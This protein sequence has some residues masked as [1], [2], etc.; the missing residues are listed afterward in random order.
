MSYF[1]IHVSL[2]KILLKMSKKSFIAGVLFSLSTCLSAQEIRETFHFLS[3]P[4]ST[5]IAALGGE[6]ISIL[7]DELGNAL[8]NP[9]LLSTVSNHTITLS[10]MN[11][12]TGVNA[13]SAAYAFTSKEHLTWAFTGEF[14]SYGK[15]TQTDEQG[16]VL[17][18]FSAKDILL[19][20]LFC[21]DFN[22]RW[23]GGVRLDLI[24]AHYEQFTA[25]AMDVNLGLNYYH[26][27]KEVS[28]SLQAAH[29]GAELKT[30]DNVREKLPFDLTLG[31]SKDLRFIPVRLSLTM[32]HLTDWTSSTNQKESAGKKLLNHLIVGIDIKPIQSFYIALGYNFQRA[33][34]FSLEGNS[35]WAGVSCGAGLQLKRI[36][37]GAAY[38]KYHPTSSSLLF[39][40]SYTL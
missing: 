39:N 4:K 7:E 9:A 36:K 19:G 25:L 34:E 38:A 13:G 26:E 31:V 10:Y 23:S 17:G 37:F 21:Y 27:E 3:L 18:S 33:D 1:K 24:Y 16:T 32:R 22:T 12:M 28:V 14:L 5:H 30:F 15:M 29:I 11:Y 6:N 40:L 8:H 35:R 2:A 20:G